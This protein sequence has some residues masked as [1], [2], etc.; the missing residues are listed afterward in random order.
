M[1]QF[2]ALHR[3]TLECLEDLLWKWDL[4]G[5]ILFDLRHTGTTTRPAGFLVALRRAMPENGKLLIAE[6]ILTGMNEPGF[7]KLLDIE[8]L[9]IPG[10]RE[11]TVDEYRAL[12]ASAGLELTRVVGTRSPVSVIEAVRP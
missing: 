7:A 6:M 1:C 9:L 8:M 4:S 10:G 2:D 12:L 5:V 3:A 11:R